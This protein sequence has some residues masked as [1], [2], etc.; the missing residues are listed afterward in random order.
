MNY[1][2]RLLFTILIFL[3]LINDTTL[4]VVAEQTPDPALI[5]NYEDDLTGDGQKE[6]ILLKGDLLSLK[7]KYYQNIWVEITSKHSERWRIP[8][9]NGYEPKIYL[10][11]LN[12]DHVNDLFY[13]VTTNEAD[14][15]NTHYLYTLKN[16][17]INEILLPKQ[18][19]I[20]GQFM[21]DFHI[22]IHLS[23]K[24]NNK[25]VFVN[26]EDQLHE[27]VKLGIYNKQG[28]LL[29]PRTV[30]INPISS[31]EP[32]HISKSKGYGLKSYQQIS[33]AYPD[34]KLG[35]IETLWYYE[36]GD[37]IVLKTDWIPF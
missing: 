19:Y 34:D 33:G 5:S 30:I 7:R 2:L 27:Y 10:F 16:G 9:K 36:N 20:K 14:K 37:W 21:N 8:F 11:D 1:Y 4:I 3:L 29:K 13:R 35:I 25:P 18:P 22:E 12:H 26:V 28:K 6:I 31:Y 24:E 17:L 23:I 32:T 15:I